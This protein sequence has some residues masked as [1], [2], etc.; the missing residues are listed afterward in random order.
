MPAGFWISFSGIWA[1]AIFAIVFI[2]VN[3]RALRRERERKGGPS[4][5]SLPPEA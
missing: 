4:T 3:H 1:V 2:A 5:G